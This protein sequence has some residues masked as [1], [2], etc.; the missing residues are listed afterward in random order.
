MGVD[1][2]KFIQSKQEWINFCKEKG[3]KSLDDYYIYCEE[4]DILPKEPSDF[5]K[6]FTNI[7][8]ELQFN[9]N[10]RR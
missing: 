10:R 6:D 1:T 4:Y 8:Y 5:Y 2:T 9:R 3:I 7:P